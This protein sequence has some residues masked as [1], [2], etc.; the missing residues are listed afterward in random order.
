M[1]F[2]VV[3]YQ[4]QLYTGLTGNF[5]VRSSKGKSCVIFCYSYN[6]NYIMLVPIKLKS[7]SEW[8][9]GGVF[10]NLTPRGFKPKLQTMDNESSASRKNYFTEKDMIY[11]LVHPHYHRINASEQSIRT[12]KEHFVVGLSSVDPDVPMHL[13]GLLL[14]QEEITLNLLRGLKVAPT[15]ILRGALPRPY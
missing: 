6:I 3:I 14:P 12:F 13:W 8:L 11:R 1:V 2:S 7:S 4:G 15:V 10:D 9:R 5:L